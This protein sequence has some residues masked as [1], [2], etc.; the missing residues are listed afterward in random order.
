M[1]I[2]LTL[3]PIQK[4]RGM[5][6]FERHHKTHATGSRISLPTLKYLFFML[7]VKGF[8]LGWLALFISSNILSSFSINAFSRGS[9]FAPEM[10]VQIIPINGVKKN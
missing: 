8:S 3:V 6:L 1:L 2:N 9:L 4:W 7:C 10:K 5:P